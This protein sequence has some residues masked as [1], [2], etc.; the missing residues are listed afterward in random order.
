MIVIDT[1]VWIDHLRGRSTSQVRAFRALVRG[2]ERVATVGV[3]RMELL[4]GVHEDD[5][6]VLLEQLDTCHFLDTDREDF[7]VAADLYRAARSAG[8]SVRNSIDCLIAASL[9]AATCVRA[10][11]PLLHSDSDFDKLAS[12][13]D[14]RVVA[15]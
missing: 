9:I 11:V 2:K 6:G 4:R 10:K 8:I 1:S 13:S 5:R 7:D 15:V 14:L 3:V 12:V